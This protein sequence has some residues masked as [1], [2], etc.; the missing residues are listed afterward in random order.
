MNH[1]HR[2]RR[3]LRDL[4]SHDLTWEKKERKEVA[5][6]ANG[7]SWKTS[8][9]WGS[10]FLFV[11]M[12]KTFV[13]FGIEQVSLILLLLYSLYGWNNENFYR[14]LHKQEDVG[15]STI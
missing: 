15:A 12:K 9:F 6:A 11:K 3:L 1:H 10:V 8:C 5:L 14:S 2:I 4:R 7:I 13:D